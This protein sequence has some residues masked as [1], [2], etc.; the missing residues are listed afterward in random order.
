MLSIRLRLLREEKKL[1]QKE[2]AD[3]FNMSDARY[4]Q[5]ETG[6]R[7]PDY[8]T[9]KLFADFFDV[10]TDYLLGRTDIRNSYTDDKTSIPTKA[11]HNLDASGLP[12]EA[13]KQVQDYIELIKLKYN[14][15]GSL[16]KK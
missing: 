14:P 8:D 11:Y 15:D 4:N 9:L 12:D 5:Y 3:I 2:M 10:T 16:K 7:S 6:K 13:I 1:T